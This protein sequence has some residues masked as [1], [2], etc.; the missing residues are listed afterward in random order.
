LTTARLTVELN[1]LAVCLPLIALLAAAISCSSVRQVRPLD[2]GE[3]SVGV[4]LGGPVTQVGGPYI[5]LPLL[6]VSYHRGIVARTFDIGGAL[7]LT[8]A[9]YGIM[10]LEAACNWRPWH[11]STWRPGLIVTPRLFLMTDFSPESFRAYPDL[12]LTLPWEPKEDWFVY[13]GIESWFE[14]HQVRD[15]GNRQPHHWLI[16]PSL[17]T[18]LGRGPWHYQLEVKLY[19]PNLANTGRPTKNI[20]IGDHGVWGVFLGIGRTFGGGER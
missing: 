8:Q 9:L 13:T 1:G 2:K 6:S 10:Q 11:G 4:S 20:G 15:D 3:S 16:A 14:P 5:P 7:Y 19:T 18:V 17:G 12:G